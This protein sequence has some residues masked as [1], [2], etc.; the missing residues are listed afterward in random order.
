[1][2]ATVGMSADVAL[3]RYLRPCVPAY[4]RTCVSRFR[5]DRSV[6]CARAQAAVADEHG[7]DAVVAR[8]LAAGATLRWMVSKDTTLNA[9]SAAPAR[10]CLGAL[11]V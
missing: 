2:F 1:M 6:R 10:V 3:Q 7:C 8:L 11:L 5:M 4:L 9:C